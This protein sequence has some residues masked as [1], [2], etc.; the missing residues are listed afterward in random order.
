[1]LMLSGDTL[2]PMH[3]QEVLWNDLPNLGFDLTVPHLREAGSALQPAI[4]ARD[5]WS[6]LDSDLTVRNSLSVGFYVKATPMP[7]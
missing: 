5:Q 6:S 2:T 3:A 7:A 1:M 4:S